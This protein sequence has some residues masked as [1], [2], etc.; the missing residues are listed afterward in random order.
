[1][2]VTTGLLVLLV[3]RVLLVLTVP[4]VFPAGI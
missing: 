1:V 3:P 2:K 4:M